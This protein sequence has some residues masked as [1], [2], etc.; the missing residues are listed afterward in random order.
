MG[1]WSDRFSHSQSRVLLRTAWSG[2]HALFWRN[3][4]GN[5]AHSFGYAFEH[6][7]CATRHR[8]HTSSGEQR[9]KQSAWE[10]TFEETG[11]ADIYVAGKN[12]AFIVNNE[13][14]DFVKN[15]EEKPNTKKKVKEE[16]KVD[17][18]T[19]D[20]KTDE[21]NDNKDTLDTNL[22]TLDTVETIETAKQE[23]KTDPVDKL[24]ESL[25]GSDVIITQE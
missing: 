5:P 22:D 24:I 19:T 1:A 16:Q 17:T 13:T 14:L 18:T 25:Q 9:R 10:N 15:E 7:H 11:I 3:K 8:P 12:E 20:T 21:N 23:E 4:D 6:H 2:T